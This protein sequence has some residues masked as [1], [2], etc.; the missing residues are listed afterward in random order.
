MNKRKKERKN[1]ERKKERNRI[2]LDGNFKIRHE[3]KF[4]NCHRRLPFPHS[5]LSPPNMTDW[6]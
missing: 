5:F 1:E 4:D 6:I 3:M 2:F